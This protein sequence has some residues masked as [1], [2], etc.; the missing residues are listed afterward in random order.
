MEFSSGP[1]YAYGLWGAVIFNVLL[2]GW[3][4]LSFLAPRRPAEWRSM[5]V[6]SAFLV[7]LFTEMYGFPLTIYILS[8]ALGSRLPA[9]PFSHLNGHLWAALLGVPDWGKLAICQIGSVIMVVALV[10]MGKA[11]KQIH[12]ARGELVTDGLYRYVRHPQYSALFLF[13]TG[14]LIQWPTIVT[15]LMWPVLVAA[16]FRLAQREEAELFAWLGEQYRA[17][18]AVTPRFFPRPR[19]RAGQGGDSVPSLPTSWE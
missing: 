15:L 1:G 2:F 4:L 7:A 16:Y 17:Y 12:A 6:A 3:F 8:S 9:N 19:A 14:L 18:M 13:T 11:W 5:G 10:V